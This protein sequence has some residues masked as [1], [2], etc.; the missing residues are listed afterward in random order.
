MVED[1]LNEPGHAGP[2]LRK[3][4]LVRRILADRPRS[5]APCTYS[6]EQ[7]TEIVA[8]ALKP[9][10]DY[11][12][13]ITHWTARELTDEI[14]KQGISSEISQRQVQ[15]F[16]DQADLRPHRS[17]YWLN[18]KIDDRDEYE[19]QVREICD[20]YIKARELRKSGTHLVST[21]EKTGIQA[22][23]RI[24]PKKSMRPGQPEKIEFEY[25]RHGTLC[26]MPSFEVDTG[27]ITAYYIGDTRNEED[28]AGHIA[29]TIAA[30]P[31]AQ[32][33]FVSD[34]L[35]T[36]MSETLVRLVAALIGYKGDLGEKDKSGILKKMKT[37]KEFLSN[38][39]HRVRFVYTPKH[40]S[41][42]NQVEIWFGILVRKVIK[43][44]NFPSADDLR[45]KIKKFIEYFNRTMAKPY[46]WT[47][48]GLP[49]TT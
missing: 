18:P 40:C 7:Y 13:P 31:N 23:E 27:K 47:Y 1:I 48:K 5:G 37:R 4:R 24:A 14:H 46:K 41:W 35:N 43:R 20:L 34:Q 6:V 44:G 29:A 33:I 17:Q 3:E 15:R 22:L 8:L 10:S 19:K 49:L 16:L 25:K 42:L 30:D 32:W 38:P 2:I 21:D 9:P 39:E 45:D 36:H 12:R 26:L 28:F 11:G